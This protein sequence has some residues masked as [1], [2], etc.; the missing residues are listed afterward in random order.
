MLDSSANNSLP[1]QEVLFIWDDVGLAPPVNWTTLLWQQYPDNNNPNDISIVQLVEQNADELRSEYLA[2]IYELGETKIEGKRVIDHLAI[3]PGFSYWWASSIG[4]KFNCS[5]NSQINDA[6]KALALE[7]FV[8]EHK[9]TGIF[10]TSDNRRLAECI[11]FFCQR[12]AINFQFK[13]TKA[14]RK[15]GLVR[16]LLHSL[17]GS[18][19]SVIFLLKYLVKTFPLHFVRHIKTLNVVGEVMFIDVLVHLDKQS[20]LAGEFRSNYWTAL[21]DKLQQ[22]DIKSNWAHLFFPHPAVPSIKQANHLINTFNLSSRDEQ[23]HIL[24]ERPIKFNTLVTVLADFFKIRRLLGRLKSIR[25]VR[26][27]GSDLDLW[28]LHVD[29]WKS[30]LNG[31]SAIDTCLKLSLFLEIFG[32]MPRQR[33]GIYIT[34]NQPWEMALI[35]AWKFSGHGR[36][37]GAPHTTVRYWDLRYFYDPRSYLRRDV[38]DV[39]LPDLLAVNGPVAYNSIL[40][41][42]YPTS[43]IVEVE[44]LRFLHLAK[45]H[46]YQKSRDLIKPLTVLVCGDFCT[47]TN[48]RLLDWLQL[49]AK[50]LPHNTIYMF[51]PHPAYP[52]K[53][54]DYLKLKLIISED[55][56]VDLLANCDIAFTSNIT[57]AVVDAYCLGVPVIQ[58]LDGDDFNTSP[59]RGVNNVEYV[60]NAMELGI[61]LG[62]AKKA[63]RSDTKPYFFLD[64][65]LPRWRYI[66][67]FAHE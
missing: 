28:A 1:K 34:E 9:F 66:L 49:A 13:K 16:S 41:G 47:T 48:F 39:P 67:D 62:S 24:V 43:R 4:Q 64:Q 33:V 7:K 11:E 6:I 50:T 44:A 60:R 20:V 19:R 58:M 57:S 61:A 55:S 54:D 12:N 3:R 25:D 51:K 65:T 15:K 59:L 38:N 56:L 26:P 8:H 52:L 23:F 14:I 32:S 22:W 45:P 10:L 42:G 2:W 63:K 40:S 46:I 30:S 53:S 36:L 35:Y 29:E 18:I 5:G 31:S 21:I 37:I 17:P 27:V